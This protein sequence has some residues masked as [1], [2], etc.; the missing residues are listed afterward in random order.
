MNFNA[1]TGSR[2]SLGARK[3]KRVS[4]VNA[5]GYN[6]YA[7]QPAFMNG[8][9]IP[10]NPQSFPQQNIPSVSPP[11]LYPQMS[12]MPPQ[13]AQMPPQ[14]AQMPQQSD[15]SQQMQYNNYQNAN[16]YNT[17]QQNLGVFAQP[18]VQN[19]AMQYGQQLADTGKTIVKK[20]IERYVPVT[21]LKYY[22]SVDTKYVI[23]KL[24]LLL[25]PFTHKDWSVKY[26]QDGRPV[27]PRYEINAPDLYI[28]TM[29]YITYVLV[30]G[31]ALGVQNRFS[32]EQI[33]IQS[34]SALAWCLVELAVYSCAL[35]V[36][37]IQTNLRTLDLVAYSGYKFFGVIVS[38]LISLVGGKS[39]YYSVLIY[40]SLALMFFLTRSLK[41]QILPETDQHFAGY[42]RRLYFLFAL[43]VA[44]PVL[45]WWLS[46]HLI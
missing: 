41:A 28:P 33:G 34:S 10:Q 45:S 15:Q 42:K 30:A 38:I 40:A 35:Y 6:P 39:A 8:D 25:F 1:N 21:H 16:M 36:A 32:P 44:Q 22:F 7:P 20:E 37:N 5:M 17:M 31:L 27:Q 23:S 46:F 9:N 2:Q 12:Q 24:K 14:M 3:V 11:N 18:V 4:D 29:A 26:E 43:A 13:M 19:M